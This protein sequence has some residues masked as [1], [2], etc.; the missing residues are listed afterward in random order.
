[1]VYHENCVVYQMKSVFVT[2]QIHQLE[3]MV[4]KK[5]ISKNL[6]A[7]D[8]IYLIKAINCKGDHYSLT[9]KCANFIRI[10]TVVIFL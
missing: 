3:Y 6:S 9:S 4:F 1:M 7:F 10:K 5:L 8:G 2:I